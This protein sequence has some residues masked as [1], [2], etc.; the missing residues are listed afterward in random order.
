MTHVGTGLRLTSLPNQASE[1]A[2]TWYPKTESQWPEHQS[3]VLEAGAD[4][5]HGLLLVVNDAHS[6]AAEGKICNPEGV[7]CRSLT[8]SHM[9]D[10]HTHLYWHTYDVDRDAVL[11][12]ARAAGI[13]KIFVVGCTVEESR[14]AVDLAQ[15]HENVYASIGI[16]PNEWNQES[17]VKNPE[18]LK[19]ELQALAQANKVVAI[20]ECGL[21]YYRHGHPELITFEDKQRQKEGFNLQLELARALKLPVIIHC[22]D[23][24]QDMYQILSEHT[25]QF[26][27]YDSVFILHCYMG[28]TE[29][30]REF[31]K[32]SH[33]YFSFTGNITYPIKKRV[34]GTK[35]DLTETVKLV[36]LER[37]F[38][39]TDCPFLT[40][41]GRRGERNEPAY[42][43]EVV[44]KVAELHGKT[45]REVERAIENN[46]RKTFSLS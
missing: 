17:G 27:I 22:R 33:V 25:S 43:A 18:T 40:P 39:E 2:Q 42:V 4:K 20:G 46:V 11:E 12:R 38:T 8:C 9:H 21:D 23:A 3:N 44:A 7:F 29:V 13:D 1:D 16:H 36:P 32:L 15:K 24:Y 10:I 6:L 5:P 41:Q 14:Q 45:A 34:A 37:M 28:D 35:N 26:S 30:T 19:R 31:L